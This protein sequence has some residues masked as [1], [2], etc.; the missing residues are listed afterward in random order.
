MKALTTFS[1]VVTALA[2]ASGSA[3]AGEGEKTFN[4]VDKNQDGIV[5][6]QEASVD[7]ALSSE[8]A[9]A[10][11]NQDGYLSRSEFDAISAMDLEDDTEEAE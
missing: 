11:A 1:A 5:T 7:R 10:D 8:F 3:L 4:E 6:Q 9:S 2:L